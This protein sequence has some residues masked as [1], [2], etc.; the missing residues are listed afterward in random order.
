MANFLDVYQD[1]RRG[2]FV[3]T[4]LSTDAKRTREY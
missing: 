4:E 2:G 1:F 3:I